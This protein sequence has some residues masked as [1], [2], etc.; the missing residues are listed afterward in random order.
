MIRAESKA[1]TS[2]RGFL[3]RGA[4]TVAGASL[5]ASPA[6][7]SP[8]GA[9]PIFDAIEKHK[10]TRAAVKVAVHQ[11]DHHEDAYTYDAV[12]LAFDA[13]TDAACTLV[14]I[15]ATTAAGLVAL[16]RYAI[17]AD[18]DGMGWPDRLESDDGKLVRSW[19]YFLVENLAETVSELNSGM[20]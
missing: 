15:K 10:V 16:L 4:A 7:T 13:E 2:R 19:H 3:A 11:H 20:V 14:S 5:L 1:T 17:E 8:A 18:T 12:E 6:F 9:D